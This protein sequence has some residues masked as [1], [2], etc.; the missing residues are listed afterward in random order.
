MC[1]MGHTDVV[2]VTRETWT[3]DPLGGE[4]VNGE[5]WGRGAVDML[6]LTASQAVAL[7]ALAKKGW[8]PK[9]T[10]V[11]LA[12]ADEEAGGLPGAGHVCKR[13]WDALRADYLL[14]ENGGTVSAP[15]GPTHA[16]LH[17]GEEGVP[18]R[19][20]RRVGTP[21]PRQGARRS[22]GGRDD[23]EAVLEERFGL[24]GGHAAVGCARESRRRALSGREA[25]PAP[26][27]RLHRRAV[28]PRARRD[29]VRLRIVLAR[30]DGRSHV[31]QIPRQR[32]A[33]RRGI[34]R[35]HHAGV[36]RYLRD[37]PRIE[38]ARHPNDEEIAWLS[39]AATF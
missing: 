1:L 29:R 14:T 9:G 20:L 2:P 7:K 36:A 22:A 4:L 12:C 28:L 15:G 27:R 33:H 19:P 13:H 31:R 38:F 39:T 10:L 37:V 21:A 26:D 5:V 24:A 11:Y 25:A 30:A 8:R 17:I 23:R 32:R 16:P 3:C 34:A 35:A 6:N 18:R